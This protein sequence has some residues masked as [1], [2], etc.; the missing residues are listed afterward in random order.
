M[1]GSGALRLITVQLT[2]SLSSPIGTDGCMKFACK[3]VTLRKRSVKLDYNL[4]SATRDL[5]GI[6]LMNRPSIVAWRTL[7]DRFLYIAKLGCPLEMS[8]LVPCR[9]SLGARA[10]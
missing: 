8:M 10:L 3:G 1:C 9:L 2:H 5:P 4:Y 7:V 6:F